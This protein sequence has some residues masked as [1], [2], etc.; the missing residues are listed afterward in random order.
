M[1]DPLLTGKPGRIDQLDVPVMT[2]LAIEGQGAPEGPAYAVAVQALYSLAYA[3]RF[4][5][6]ARGIEEK[7]GPLEGLWWADDMAAY[8][9]GK[10]DDWR[11]RMII[12]APGWL[13]ADELAALRPGVAAKRKDKPE[14]V[15]ALERVV[16][17]ELHEGL[18]LQALHVGPYSAEAPLIARMH[19]EDMPARGL[20]PTGQ[21]H[22]IYLS[23]PRRVAPEK[24]KTILRQPVRAKG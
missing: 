8:T 5:G 23:D 13:S 2:Y 7:V 22:E 19:S 14:V 15:A 21:H 12:R 6:K 3:A 9:T 10:R 17:F 11:W 1:K 20:E 4:A 18:C 24:L 16:L